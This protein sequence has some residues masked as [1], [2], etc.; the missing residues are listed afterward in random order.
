MWEVLKQG[1][2]GRTESWKPRQGFVGR[3]RLRRTVPHY[4][5]QRSNVWRA[6]SYGNILRWFAAHPRAVG[7]LLLE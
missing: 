5:N 2:L 3:E 7:E 1:D 6:L 4:S